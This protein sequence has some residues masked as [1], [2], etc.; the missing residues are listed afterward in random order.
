MLHTTRIQV[1]EKLRF[2]AEPHPGKV[3]YGGRDGCKSWGAAQQLVLDAAQSNIRTLCARET[4]KSMKDSVHKLLCDT[5]MR[6]GLADRFKITEDSIVGRNGTRTQPPSEFLFAGIKEAKNIKSY[7]SCDRCWVE[8][9]QV[10]SKRSWE[11]LIPTIRKTG[12]EFWITFNPELET[13]E[14]YQRWVLNP[15]PG[16]VVVK[17]GYEDNLWLSD[18]SKVDI[19]HLLENDPVAFRH[20]YGGECR[21]AVDGAVYGKELG[22]AKE[23]GRVCSVAR[24]PMRPV[25]T[26]W[27]LG[28]R[29]P[30]AVWFVQ[31][32]GGWFNF[33]DYMERADESIDWWIIQLQQ[34][35]YRYGT[36]W[37]PHDSID[38]ITH[39]RLAGGDRSHSIE[40]LMRQAYPQNTRVVPKLRLLDTINAGRMLFPVSRFDE[41]NCYPG[42]RALAAYQWGPRKETSFGTTIEQR[43]PVHDWASHAASAFGYA[44]IILRQPKEH[45]QEQASWERGMFRNGGPK[46]EL[47]W[48][49]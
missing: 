40:M 24:D 32:Y 10:V 3:L 46:D 6:F 21:S 11:I 18:K 43:D 49:A 37:L 7:E 27:D 20:I 48:M 41:G 45:T 2:L 44:G 29:D 36:H 17:L 26:I 1:H 33:I 12:S 22:I 14:T 42:L 9:A 31:S 16:T 47:S 38:T 15:P 8:E 19:A 25:D 39:H 23:E 28:F 35:G 4:Q 5:I 13:D 34:K 30:T